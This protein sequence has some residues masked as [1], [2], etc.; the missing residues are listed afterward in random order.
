MTLRYSLRPPAKAA[1]WWAA[2]LCAAFLSLLLLKPQSRAEDRSATRDRLNPAGIEGALVIHGGGKL[3]DAVVERFMELAGGEKANIVVILTA[4]ES[5]DKSENG[6]ALL[7]P[8]KSRKAAAV[9]VLHTRSRKTADDA[10]FV[11]PLRKA[12]GVWFTGGSQARLAETYVGTAVEKELHEL[13]KRGGVIGGTSAGAAIMSRLMIVAGEP[14]AQTG[15]GF[16]LLPGAVVDQHFLVRKHQARLLEV[17]EKHPGFVGF[18]ID[19]GTALIVRGRQLRVL[20]DSSVTVCL[21]ASRDR[22]A[23]ISELKPGTVADLTQLR[24]SAIARGEAAAANKSVPVPEV[25]KG[26]LVIVGGGGMPDEVTKKFIELA[27]G[28]EA[29]IVVLPTANPDP[30]PARAEATFLARAGAKNL[31]V[32][33][34]RELKDV[35]DPQN[36]EVLKQAKGIWFGGG[37]QWRFVDAYENT[38]ARA[39]FHDVL[40]RGGVIGGSSAGAT[41]QGDYLCRGS[42]LNNTD[43]MCEGYEHGLCF[44]P[45]VAI[46]QH[47]SQRKRHG[48]MTA[49]MKC[50]PQFLG[51]GIDEA[52]ALVVQGHVAEILGRGAAHFYDGAKHVA[53]GSPDYEAVKAGGQ[54]DLKARKVLP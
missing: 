4:G 19:E 9:A 40:R 38:K 33:P 54:Y 28:P 23:K 52:T 41:I 31:K 17:I 46:D 34:G 36:L 22:E 51:I 45:G 5:A 35:D 44:L 7:E 8:W 1:M 32:L 48:D 49:F 2:L 47:F 39:L 43:V 24:R 14:H 42:P 50:C 30:V 16:D 10:A 27:G 25:A 15:A 13:L 53:D 29:L 18:G 37:R 20:G 12:T 21:A 26:S 3:P 6:T 11:E